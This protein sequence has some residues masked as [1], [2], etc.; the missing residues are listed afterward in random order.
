[1]CALAV[2]SALLFALVLCFQVPAC[3]QWEGDRLILPHV[4]IGLKMSTLGAGVELATPITERTNLRVGFNDFVYARDFSYDGSLYSAQLNLF[5][6]Q[7]NYDWFP[8]GNSFHLSP[9]LLA[10]NGNHLKANTSDTAASQA[11]PGIFVN[12]ITGSARIAFGKVAP[13][14][15]MGWGNLIPRRSRRF[16][17]PFEFGVVY[18]GE[19][20]TSLHM[21]PIICPAGDMVCLEASADPSIQ[22]GFQSEQVE[23]RKEVSPYKLYPVISLGFGYR[24]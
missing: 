23:I 18:H 14:F 1:M 15:L 10:Y 13:M 16:S 19:P 6:V 5:S 7:A 20:K 24:F 3:A 4:G 9:G 2:V 22:S 12:P 8:F 21:N 17:I 11:E